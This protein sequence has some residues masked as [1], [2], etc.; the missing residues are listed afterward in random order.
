MLL[1][2]VQSV[3]PWQL[4]IVL[5]PVVIVA[6]LICWVIVLLTRRATKGNRGRSICL[7]CGVENPVEAKFCAGCG[8]E[9]GCEELGE[10]ERVGV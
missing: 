1:E 2:S 4:L 7:K 6:V 8:T 10:D 5:T 3:S 9:L